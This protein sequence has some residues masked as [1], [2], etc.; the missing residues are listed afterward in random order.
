MARLDIDNLIRKE[1]KPFWDEVVR[2][3]PDLLLNNG[4]DFTFQDFCD[5]IRLE[6]TPVH[7][8]M[9]F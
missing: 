3:N 6:I 1:A 5:E 8:P 2:N 9:N 4:P 7:A